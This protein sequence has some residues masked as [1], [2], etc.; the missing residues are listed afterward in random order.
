MSVS[1]LSPEL[2]REVFK[3]APDAIYV[4]NLDG[5]IIEANQAACEQSGFSREVLL[6][7]MVGDI[8][9]VSST[10]EILERSRHM[11]Q[12][13]PEQMHFF[14]YH[15]RACGDVL[16]VDL[17]VTLVRR[18][19]DPLFAAVVRD[20]TERRGLQAKLEERL[21]FD[22]LLLGISGQLVGVSPEHLDTVMCQL[23]SLIGQFFGVDRALF[24]GTDLDKR[25]ITITH[26]WVVDPVEV[27]Q[28]LGRSD[29]FSRYPWIMNNLLQHRVVQ[30]R[31]VTAMSDA[32]RTD[33]EH[34]LEE[35]VLSNV[36]VPMM[37]RGNL[38]GA[39]CLQGFKKRRQLSEE[40]LENLRLLVQLIAG[41]MD[42]V[43]LGREL[44]HRAFHDALTGLGNRQLLRD[45]IAHGLQRCQRSGAL[46]AIFLLDLDD[47][48]LINDT[49]GHEAGDHLL[50]RMAQRL[51]GSV[52]ALG[53]VARLGGD[54]FVVLAE[55]N[56]IDDVAAM[57]QGILNDIS[58][59]LH[60]AGQDMLVHPSIGISVYPQDGADADTLLRHADTALYEA[61]REGKNR[62]SFYNPAMSVEADQVLALRYELGRAVR[63]NQ[64]T[65]HYQPIVDLQTGRVRQLEA[66][67]R[68]RHPQQG[69]LGPDS[70]L[71]VAERSDLV[72]ELDRW[73]AHQ[74]ASRAMTLHGLPVSINVSLRDVNDSEQVARLA[75]ILAMHQ[76]GQQH[77]F[78]IEITE[79]MLMQDVT[80]VIKHLRV[81]KQRVPSL[82]IAIDDFGSGYSSLSVLRQLPIDTLKVAPAFVRDLA[83]AG[84]S[85]EAIVRSVFHLARNL[86]V[87]IIAEGVERLDQYWA[88]R[89]LAAEGS[90][91]FLAQG[92]LISH[93]L[94]ESGLDGI[95]RASFDPGRRGLLIP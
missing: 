66:L 83:Q 60:L 1:R 92:Y 43:E 4:Y 39:L 10:E 54:E 72:C 27:P 9:E 24:C 89:R 23:L 56:E 8:S 69:L 31:D 37:R 17:G 5:C 95:A 13:G 58:Q 91:E 57:A 53:T 44:S 18:G 52:S 12:R 81:L 55:S 11:L 87:R 75:E 68:W 29:S 93:P 51:N 82:T 50:R 70:F 45:R 28:S 73:A 20:A 85:A 35:R 41:S 79:S 34:L 3:A 21:V 47:F 48:K 7:L 33:R 30:I 78:E 42:A 38:H 84:S 59:P 76:H 2:C 90:G 49:L 6:K 74:A 88:L 25:W 46:L 15:R 64:L 40:V 71:S 26:E 62:A 65:L 36:I 86:D 16:P 63:D 77:S 94:A 80:V 67:V 32:A 14:S 22:E 61:K 19:D